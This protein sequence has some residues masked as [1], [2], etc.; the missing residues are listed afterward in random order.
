MEKWKKN[1]GIIMIKID[2]K[3]HLQEIAQDLH[4]LL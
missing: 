4:V 2:L 1:K 3:V